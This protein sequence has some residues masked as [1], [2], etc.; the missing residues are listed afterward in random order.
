MSAVLSAEI[1]RARRRGVTSSEH[2][3][4]HGAMAQLVAHHTG[5]V[6][7]RGSSPLSSTITAGQGPGIFVSSC[8]LNVSRAVVSVT[9]QECW[10]LS[11]GELFYLVLTCRRLARP[12]SWL[13]CCLK[14]PWM[15][16]LP[17]PRS[18]EINRRFAQVAN[19]ASAPSRPIRSAIE[20]GTG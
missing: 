7:V 17:T 10:S 15:A 20:F 9:G 16:L 4:K 18:P 1:L 6:G 3:T 19:A 12:R 5:S 11:R 14:W 13:R 2:T 8:W